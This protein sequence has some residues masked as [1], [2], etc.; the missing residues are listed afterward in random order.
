MAYYHLEILRKLFNCLYNCHYIAVSQLIR[1]INQL[2]ET[3][4]ISKTKG[5]RKKGT[6]DR[7][8]GKESELY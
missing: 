1:I 7:K 2:A 8:K 3:S 5:K 4:K 6:P